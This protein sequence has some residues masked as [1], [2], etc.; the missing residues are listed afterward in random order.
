MLRIGLKENFDL[1]FIALPWNKKGGKLL[2]RMHV[3]LSPVLEEIIMSCLKTTEFVLMCCF[4]EMIFF[5]EIVL[6]IE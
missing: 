4:E 1:L 5:T 6:V 2:K 3:I